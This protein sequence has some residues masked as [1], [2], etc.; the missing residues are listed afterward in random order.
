MLLAAYGS[1]FSHDIPPARYQGDVT[2]TV[3]FASHAEVTRECARGRPRPPSGKEY[4]GCTKPDGTIW[5]IDPCRYTSQDYALSM[6]HELG[7]LHG[8]PGDHP[9]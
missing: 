3:R 2:A 9:L 6:C 5:M 8:W 7:H 1:I 4:S